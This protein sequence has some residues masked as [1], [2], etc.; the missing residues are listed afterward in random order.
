MKTQRKACL[1]RMP[2]ELAE[3]VAERA[4]ADQRSFNRQVC[5]MLST[6]LEGEQANAAVVLLQKA[7]AGK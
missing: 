7:L 6:A 5:F 1:V 4:A 3:R 2:V